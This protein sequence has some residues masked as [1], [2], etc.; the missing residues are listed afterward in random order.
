MKKVIIFLIGVILFI[1]KEQLYYLL[2][3]KLKENNVYIDSKIE[4]KIEKLSLTK[5][6]IYF[7]EMDI[8]TFDK[9]DIYPFLIYN[10]LSCANIKLNIGNYLIKKLQLKNSIIQ[11]LQVEIEGEANFGK[12]SGNIDLKD[13]KVKI[14]ISEIKDNSIK[15]FLKRDKKGYFYDEVF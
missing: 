5:G 12:I 7:N 4:E 13:R 9:S 3:Q 11:P 8:L 10:Q 6:V 1:P 14:Y 15:Q 2:Q